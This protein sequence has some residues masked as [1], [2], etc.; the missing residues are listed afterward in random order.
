MLPPGPRTPAFWQTLRFA[1]APRE[2][3]RSL[4]RYGRAQR[5]RALNGKGISVS[6]S[7]LAREVFSTDPAF[8]ETPG[9]LSELFGSLSVLARRPMESRDRF[10][11]A[12]R[13][14][15]KRIPECPGFLHRRA[16]SVHEDRE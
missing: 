2:Y 4:A 14:H 7:E 1:S 15:G 5:F 3:S 13:R 6:D 16:M 12:R 9:V 10:H 11:L 8:F